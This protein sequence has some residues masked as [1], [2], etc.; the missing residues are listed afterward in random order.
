MP[1]STR[2]R[3]RTEDTE[4]EVPSKKRK[5]KPEV[6]EV[7]LKQQVQAAEPAIPT[8]SEDFW[9]DDGN[10]IIATK[11]SSF[12][13]HATILMLRSEVFKT[14]LSVP[15][16]AE[17]SEKV[18]GCPVRRID[19]PGD[20]F[21]DLLEVVYKGGNSVWLDSR[22]LPIAYDDFR[23]LVKIA[24]KYDVT[25]IINE[26]KYRLAR[27]FPTE[28]LDKWD[29]NLQPD[30]DTTP[31]I[32]DIDESIDLLHLVRDLEMETILPLGFYTCCNIDNSEIFASA[33]YN[34]EDI[35]I[36]DISKCLEGRKT[37]MEEA[38]VIMRSFLEFA[39]SSSQRPPNC[40]TPS[41]CRLAF[42]FLAL[43]SIDH[44]WHYY[45]SPLSN[46]DPYLDKEQM[47]PNSKLCKPCDEALRKTLNERRHNTWRK[48][49]EIFE[50]PE[51]PAGLQA[52]SH[53][54]DEPVAHDSA[55]NS[56]SASAITHVTA[57]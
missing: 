12:R 51:W 4:L 8:R 52:Q 1:A 21:H 55:A 50:V 14:L 33:Q 25:E 18:E 28:S 31:I 34:E 7:R 13:V 44:G 30:G 43:W 5:V 24:L 20:S 46:L 38:S 6:P 53:T 29:P 16:L 2:S 26:A 10:V 54:T 32:I 3:S 27:V 19:D 48:L 49:G 22:R 39:V 57:P 40:S 42:E 41:R 11:D 17:L 15:A 35:D 36:E 45:P 37:L 47:K 23:A 56:A 9:F